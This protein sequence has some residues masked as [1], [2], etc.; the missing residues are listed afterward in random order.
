[1]ATQDYENC[2]VCGNLLIQ[3]VWEFQG[4]DGTALR[5]CREDDERLHHLLRSYGPRI[6]AARQGQG[7]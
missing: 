6:E 4:A 7:R 2:D 3:R 5:A 1:M